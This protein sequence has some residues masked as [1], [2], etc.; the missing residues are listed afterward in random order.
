MPKLTNPQNE[1]ISLFKAL[2][3]KDKRYCLKVLSE[4][5]EN[6]KSKPEERTMTIQTRL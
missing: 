5:V 6:L 3:D 2:P 4:V 1:I